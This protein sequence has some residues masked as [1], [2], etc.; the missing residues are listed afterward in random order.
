MRDARF[1]EGLR[2]TLDRLDELVEL[3]RFDSQMDT[4]YAFAILQP[5]LRAPGRLPN[6]DSAESSELLSP[7]QRAIPNPLT[8][9]SDECSSQARRHSTG[10]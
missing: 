10:P 3:P 6:S 8:T 7:A 1:D 9:S 5:P 4:S 2:Q